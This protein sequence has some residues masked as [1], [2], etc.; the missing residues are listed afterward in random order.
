MTP[1]MEHAYRS[2][3]ESVFRD[4]LFAL[5]SLK[6]Q[7]AFAITATLTIAL[8]I[9]ATSAIFSVV[10]AVL[11][12]PLPYTNA[13]RLGTVWSDL[14]NRN[15][16][17]FPL[18]PGDFYDLRKDTTLFEGF[19]AITSFRPTVGGDGQ[20]E[21]EQVSGGAVTTNFFSMLGHRIQIGRDFVDEDG[22]PN[23][24]P[25]QDGLGAQAPPPTPP[26]PNI[27]II[28]HEFWQRRF[29]GNE[30][31][32]GQSIPFGNG[33]AEIVG[34]LAPRFEILFPPGT[35]VDPRPDILV[36]SRANFEAGSRNNVSLRVIARLKPG[37]S[38]DQAQSELDR[39]SADLRS[40]FPIKQTANMNLRIEPMHDDLVAD[41][42]PQLVA[43]MGAVVFVLLI[44]C[45][46][47]A[48][49]LLVRASARERELAVRAAIGGNRWRIVRQLVAESLVLAA[50]GGAA[51]LL[52]AQFGID[53]LIQLS[54]EGL[55]RATEVSLDGTVL[56]FSA[57]AALAAAL[58]FGVAPAIRASR[59][60][61]MDVLR[62]SGR[63]VGG[64]SGRWL[65]DGAVIAEVALAFVLLV[66][67]GLMIRTFVALQNANPGFDANNVF[68]FLIQNN[69]AQGVEGREAFQ[70]TMLERLK[71]VPGVID[72]T[73]AGPIPLDGGNSLARFGPLD[74]ATDPAKFQQATTY[75]VQPNF[76]TFAKT[77]IVA[78]RAFSDADNRPEARV[79]IIDELIAAQLFPNGNAIG[80]R[81]LARVITNEAEPFEV[82]GV[83]KHQ[84]HTTM[85]NDGEEGMYFPDGY[86]QFGAAF[87]WAVRTSGNPEAIA[88]AVRSALSEQDRRL[89]LTEPRTWRSYLDEQI[90]PTRFALILIGVFAAV[91]AILA[92]IGLYGVLATTVRQRTTEIGVRMAFG[93]SH[94]S[95]L[96][97]I[98]GQGLRLSI[99][100]I[101]L[102]V[103][104]AIALTRVMASLLV[105]VTATDPATFAAMAV[106]FTLIAAFAAWIPALRAAALN[107]NVALRDE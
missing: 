24:G 28:S 2:S 33:R 68:T 25:P 61:V 32:V 10:N 20:G 43:L 107:P 103:L 106:L 98:I 83:V 15:V 95:I 11:L 8:G 12:R 4:V 92:M 48:N 45:A 18:P 77:P 23:P 26:L 54:P 90:A 36:A 13:A 101:A 70:R 29:G 46:N 89:L 78:G 6:R 30:A 99:G 56:A 74:A 47:V 19:A 9:G 72:A 63:L 51:G 87:R 5:R 66:G 37:V 94:G 39:L 96:S 17:D 42:R 80:Q 34:V 93:A 49:L 97:L 31:I 91:A 14:R 82:I 81:M 67:S 52:L 44:A 84:R 55:P 7:P 27:A 16:V 59:P 22:T 69:R 100:G 104:A 65:R 105:G 60:D 75:F 53:A 85:M 38:F 64:H 62:S 86:G 79:I 102:G 40:R 1:G 58:V 35:N 3:M 57:L 71:A 88:N 76:F 73:S 21:A 50:V 41:V